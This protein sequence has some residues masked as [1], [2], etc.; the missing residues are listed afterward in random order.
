MYY[1]YG[2]LPTRVLSQWGRYIGI[3]YLASLHPL[4]IEFK[5]FISKHAFLSSTE[6]VLLHSHGISLAVLSLLC[7]VAALAME[8]H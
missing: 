2:M 3:K 6:D 8:Y 7:T 1:V 5:S 4:F